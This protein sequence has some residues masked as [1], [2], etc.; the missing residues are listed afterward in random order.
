MIITIVSLCFFSFVAGLVDAAVGGGGLIMMPALLAYLQEYTPATIFGIN[1][2][3]STLGTSFA[4]YSFVRKV[5]IDWQAIL[6]MVVFAFCMGFL[7]AVLASSIPKS[8]MKYIVLVLLICL[9]AYNFLKRDFGDLHIERVR[10]KKEKILS[11][12]V[13]GLIGFYDGF[14]GPGAGTFFVFLFVRFFSYDMLHASA[15]TKI[16]NLVTNL[17]ALIYFLKSGNIVYSISIPLAIA[18]ILGSML[19]ANIAINKGVK[20][21]KKLYLILITCL[22]IVFIK[23]TFFPA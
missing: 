4:A 9:A 8:L 15:A 16:L 21:I 17:A 1:K 22:I 14:F 20:F 6:P 2:F 11:F 7:G 10:T 23:Q 12:I 13:G 3:T 18:S 19:G 5:K